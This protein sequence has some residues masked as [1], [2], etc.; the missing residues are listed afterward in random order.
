M[1]GNCVL[2][3]ITTAGDRSTEGDKGRFVTAIEEALEV[4]DVDLAVHSAKDLPGS[5]RSGLRIAA[6]PTREDPRDALVTAA[7]GVSIEDLPRGASIGTS[8]LRR[9]AQLL[10]RR[11]DLEIVSVNGN[12][13]SRLARLAEG[14]FDGLVLAAA[15]LNRLGRSNEIS[16]YL[17]PHS[18]TPSP[19]QGCVAV[20]SR[21]GDPSQEAAGQITDQTSAEELACERAAA[22]KLEADCDSAVG[23]LA[24]ATEDSVTVRGWCGLPDGS[25]W[26]ADSVEGPR[27]E[28]RDLGERVA[29]RLLAAGAGEIIERSGEMVS[30]EETP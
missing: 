8:S 28:A 27:G 11:P 14:E 15:G 5:D 12:V 24:S 26:I 13:D 20:Q 19:G 21:E 18:F 3:V 25:E 7:S 2:E 22:R 29:E 23:I 16:S 1:L 4:G 17:D 6:V 30:R 9:R 10:S